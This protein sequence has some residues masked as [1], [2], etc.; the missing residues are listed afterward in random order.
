MYQLKYRRWDNRIELVAENRMRKLLNENISSKPLISPNKLKAIYLSPFEWETLTNLYIIDLKTG[1][2]T[3]LVGVIDEKYAPKAAIWITD[4]HIAL[5]IGYA[6]G[7]VS[8][9]GNIHIYN[10]L[11]RQMCKITEWDWRTQAI[12]LEYNGEF[13]R[14]EGVEYLSDTLSELKEIQGE[15]D[16]QRYIS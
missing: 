12:K 15:L 7:M 1:E 13:L 2:Y 9:G 8:D 10:L 14:F 5:I 4:I 16:I 3:K 11:N 6:F